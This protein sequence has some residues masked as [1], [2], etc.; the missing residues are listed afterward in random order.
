MAA[1][2]GQAG[3]GISPDPRTIS[4]AGTTKVSSGELSPSSRA[5]IRSAAIVPILAGSWASTVIP[6]REQVGQQEVVEADLSDP[7]LQLQM[8]QGAHRPQRHQVLAR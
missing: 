8:V 2:G 5:K 1:V 4:R 7:I 6:G 3:G